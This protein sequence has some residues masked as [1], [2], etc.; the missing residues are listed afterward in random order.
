MSFLNKDFHSLKKDEKAYSDNYESGYNCL[1]RMGAILHCLGY[2]IHVR[3]NIDKK[4]EGE[5]QNLTN[6]DV[7]GIRFDQSAEFL[8]EEAAKHFL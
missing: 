2:L 4:K 5:N 3:A 6:D 1:S 7:K 8:A